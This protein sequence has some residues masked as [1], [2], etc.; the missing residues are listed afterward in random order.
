[1]ASVLESAIRLDQLEAGQGLA[2]L[3][4]LRGIGNAVD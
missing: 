4:A 3:L 2:E 1:M